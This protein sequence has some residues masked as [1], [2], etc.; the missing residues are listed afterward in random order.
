MP[1]VG[2]SLGSPGG[3]GGGG[4]AG[5]ATFA[6]TTV[7]ASGPN[8]TLWGY[9][10]AKLDEG[11]TKTRSN[12]GSGGAITSAAGFAAANSWVELSAPTGT[13]Y[14]LVKKGA[15][16]TTD[17]GF[18]AKSGAFT[19]GG[20]GVLP[21]GGTADTSEITLLP[22]GAHTAIIR[23]QEQAPWGSQ[24]H[25]DGGPEIIHVKPSATTSDVTI[26][27]DAGGVLWFFPMDQAVLADSLTNK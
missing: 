12:D 16:P 22:L 14:V 8:D 1:Y 24:I 26:M 9:V 2:T 15:T 3:G 17:F 23:I 19:G 6:E 18:A 20:S 11:W 5:P 4:G 21:T 27:I 10:A 13:L 7:V 25:V